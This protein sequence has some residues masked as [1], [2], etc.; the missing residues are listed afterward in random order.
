MVNIRGADRH[1]IE[2]FGGEHLIIVAVLPLGRYAELFSHFREPDGVDVRQRPDLHV[3]FLF[4]V[5]GQVHVPNGACA[6]HSNLQLSHATLFLLVSSGLVARPSDC[7][8]GG[9]KGLSA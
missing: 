9:V 3:V 2:L 8:S 1:H 6:D 4:G 5:P 7:K